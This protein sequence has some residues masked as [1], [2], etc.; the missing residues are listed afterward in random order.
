VLQQLA[1]NV[2]FNANWYTVNTTISIVYAQIPDGNY[3]EIF[4]FSFGALLVSTPRKVRLTICLLL[5]S[6]LTM[7]TALS[8]AELL[9]GD[10]LSE[11]QQP[12]G[13]SHNLS[14]PA[15]TGEMSLVDPNAASS[16]SAY[17]YQPSDATASQSQASVS[18]SSSSGRSN[19]GSQATQTLALTRDANPTDVPQPKAASPEEEGGEENDTIGEVLQDFVEGV[20]Q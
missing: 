10:I 16:T 14:S 5:Y 17:I 19:D 4:P 9:D 7:H 8:A 2:T 20:G 6:S 1:S 18:S 11:V 12:F 15:P 3:S 13:I